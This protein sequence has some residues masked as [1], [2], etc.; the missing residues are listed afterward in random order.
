MTGG[1]LATAGSGLTSFVNGSQQHAFFVGANHHVH[2]LYFNGSSWVDQDLTVMTG[3]A[4]ATA[5]GGLASFADATG[6]HVFYG[7]VRPG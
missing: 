2:Q 7:S 1:A 4:L 5:G 3:S 6:Q